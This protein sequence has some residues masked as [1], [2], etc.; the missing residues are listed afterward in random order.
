VFGLSAL[1]PVQAI[2][3]YWE[4]QARLPL[5]LQRPVLQEAWSSIGKPRC[6]VADF[7]LDQ[8]IDDPGRGT[9]GVSHS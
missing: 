2:M 8:L 3:A 9:A 4:M 7:D 1:H 5:Y 6:W